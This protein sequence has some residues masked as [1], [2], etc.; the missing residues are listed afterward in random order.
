MGTSLSAPSH[1]PCAAPSAQGVVLTS[2]WLCS[3]GLPGRGH[4]TRMGPT[5]SG[6]CG[7]LPAADGQM[8]PRS[9][10][11]SRGLYSLAVWSFLG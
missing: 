5:S 7:G 11:G 2:R 4:G 6:E 10:P 1:D 3:P 9:L 8:E